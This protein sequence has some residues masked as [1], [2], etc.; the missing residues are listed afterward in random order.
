MDTIIQDARKGALKWLDRMRKEPANYIENRE[1]F[2]RFVSDGCLDLGSL[3]TSKV[4]LETLRRK[5]YVHNALLTIDLISK[6]KKEDQVKGNPQ[7]DLYQEEL[8]K[9]MLAGNFTESFLK[10]LVG[11]KRESD[12]FAT[13][14]KILPLPPPGTPE[15]EKEVT[16]RGYCKR[17]A[18][19]WLEKILKEPDMTEQKFDHYLHNLRLTMTSGGLMLSD[20]DP[21]LTRAK[22]DQYDPRKKIKNIGK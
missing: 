2:D 12:Y 8:R 7:F 21:S 10:K 16:R 15:Y 18:L 11:D 14:R 3:G 4:E 22:L 19:G 9:E 6:M 1:F 20:L 17:S 5:H 13:T